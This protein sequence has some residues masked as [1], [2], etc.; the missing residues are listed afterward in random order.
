MLDDAQR[1]EVEELVGRLVP[2]LV[3]EEVTRQLAQRIAEQVAEQL[4]GLGVAPPPPP[5]TDLVPHTKWEGSRVTEFVFDPPFP[6]RG[7]LVAARGPISFHVVQL[8]RSE[9]RVD[10]L[11][12][13]FVF[14][15]D[16]G[17]ELIVVP[18]GVT[19]LGIRGE[20]V[21]DWQVEVLDPD[22]LRELALPC[23]GEHSEVFVHRL[24]A[25]P[26]VLRSAD[27]IRV[28][29]YETC[30]C[31]AHCREYSH[32]HAKQLALSHKRKGK[33]ELVLPAE[34]GIVHI[35]AS[36]QWSLEAAPAR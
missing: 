35:E 20:Y 17:F 22:E 26:A 27:R 33:T 6:H 30:D 18:P 8:V 15:P 7:R 9:T 4:A 5:Q 11:R 16:G 34:Q 19:H 24:G 14:R 10:T 12:E 13:D 31:A 21:R 36:K 3:A 2:K 28:D 1:E 23:S 29:F 32:L 25:M